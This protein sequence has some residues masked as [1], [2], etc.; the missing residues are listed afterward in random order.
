VEALRQLVRR[1][2]HVEIVRVTLSGPQDLGHPPDD[3]VFRRPGQLTDLL[4][5]FDE[6]HGRPAGRVPRR[7]DASQKLGG[8]QSQDGVV[9]GG[10]LAQD[11]SS[12]RVCPLVRPIV[13]GQQAD[14]SCASGFCAYPGVELK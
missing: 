13:N 5:H 9:H 6:F 8:A 1:K 2:H 14:W 11:V 10:T 3:R 7:V 12:V 4:D